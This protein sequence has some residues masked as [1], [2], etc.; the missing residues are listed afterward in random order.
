MVMLLGAVALI[1]RISGN[2]CVRDLVAVPRA[3]G[4]CFVVGALLM[5][6]AVALFGVIGP[7]VSVSAVFAGRLFSVRFVGAAKL[8]KSLIVTGKSVVGLLVA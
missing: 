8:V 7:G 4:Y 2:A 6:V 3:N 5:A 1:L